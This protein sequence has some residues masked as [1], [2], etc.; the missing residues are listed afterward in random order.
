M[1]I[2][3]GDTV[4][5]TFAPYFHY[6]VVGVYGDLIVL[7]DKVSNTFTTALSRDILPVAE[8]DPVA[9]LA[10]WVLG[11]VKQDEVYTVPEVYNA[12]YAALEAAR[13]V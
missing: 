8:P 9:E 10:E 4:A 11:I 6:V 5:Y 3:L 2:N 12:I 13:D 7:Q 1:D